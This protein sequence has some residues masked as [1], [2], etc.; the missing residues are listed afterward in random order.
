MPPYWFKPHLYN[1]IDIELGIRISQ[2]IRE[3]ATGPTLLSRVY[4]E[5][6][7]A[8]SQSRHFKCIKWYPQMTF[9][10]YNSIES[11]NL[12]YSVELNGVALPCQYRMWE[13]SNTYI[14]TPLD[15]SCPR[16]WS[17]IGIGSVVAVVG[18]LA[19]S[20]RCYAVHKRQ[21]TERA[22]LPL[23]RYLALL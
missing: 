17:A 23:T 19:V 6:Y 7:P 18:L 5:G 4:D 11:V 8:L 2:L 15:G 12:S 16:K 10:W 14:M 9:G 1:G 13:G 22:P 3:K 21:I 20:Y